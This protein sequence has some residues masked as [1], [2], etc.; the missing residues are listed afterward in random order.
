LKILGGGGGGGGGGG[1]VVVVVV[2]VCLSDNYWLGDYNNKTRKNNE[3]IDKIA[4][5]EVIS[6]VISP[7]SLHSF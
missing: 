3:N 5:K 1:V 6:L 7:Q 2:V 4:T